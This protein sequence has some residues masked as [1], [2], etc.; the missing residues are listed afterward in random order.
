MKSWLF[1]AIGMG[2][3]SF[4]PGMAQT[5]KLAA[6]KGWHDSFDSAKAAAKKSGKP[7]LFVF[8]CEP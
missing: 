8:R 5:G 3:L 2:L 6:T 1:A 4:G 7:I